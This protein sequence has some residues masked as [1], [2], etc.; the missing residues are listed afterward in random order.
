MPLN[1]NDLSLEI[2]P[3]CTYPL[4]QPLSLAEAYLS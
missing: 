2:L 1:L 4:M 3:K